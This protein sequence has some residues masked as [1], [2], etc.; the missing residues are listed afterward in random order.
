M[1]KG[2]NVTDLEGYRKAVLAREAEGSTG[3]G[4]GIA[5]PHAKT[6]AVSAPGLASMIV[7]SGVEY[8]SLDDEPA[9]LFF[10][11]A[12]PAGGAN[13]HLE[14]LSRLS[15]MLM[16]DEF[17]EKLMNAKTADEYLA[18]IDETETA[19]LAAEAEEEAAEAETAPADEPASPAPSDRP[20]SSASRPARRAS[21]T[22]TWRRKPWKAREPLWA[23]T[24]KSKQ[25]APAASKTI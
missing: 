4:E 25:T 17:R 14:V 18:V 8:E 5:I 20:S 16:D 10:L 21:P 7:R 9:F 3:I 13:V 23:S 19:Q 22:P 24:L 12:A 2:G 11:I 1:D 15:R 6:D